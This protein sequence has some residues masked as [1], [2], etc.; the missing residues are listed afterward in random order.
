MLLKKELIYIDGKDR[1]DDIVAYSYRDNVCV[2]TF[3][4]S[5]TP[6]TYGNHKIKIV[7]SAINSKNAYNLFNYL[8]KIADTVGIKTEDGDNI[9]ANSYST[10][11][12]ISEN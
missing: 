7:K 2:I 9:L 8:K 12:F 6:Y 11:S 1:T 4:H 5:N 10:I 3:K